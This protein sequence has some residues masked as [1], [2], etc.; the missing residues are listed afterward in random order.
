MEQKAISAGPV[1]FKVINVPQLVQSLFNTIWLCFFPLL[2]PLFFVFADGIQNQFTNRV[3]WYFSSIYLF[4]FFFV[5]GFV[6]RISC[7]AFESQDTLRENYSAVWDQ[8]PFKTNLHLKCITKS[9]A[10]NI[11]AVARCAAVCGRSRSLSWLAGFQICHAGGS[12]CGTHTIALS[13]YL[14]VAHYCNSCCCFAFAFASFS[15]ATRGVAV[16]ATV[17]AAAADSIT[18]RWSISCWHASNFSMPLSLSPS[19]SLSR[20]KKEIWVNA[21]ATIICFHCWLYLYL[22]CLRLFTMMLDAGWLL[23]V[24]L[25]L[26]LIRPWVGVICSAGRINSWKVN[27]MMICQLFGQ[28]PQVPHIDNY[29]LWVTI[30]MGK[31]S[32]F[33]FLWNI[34][35]HIYIQLY[36]YI[37]T[38]VYGII[39]FLHAMRLHM[40][41]CCMYLS[42]CGPSLSLQCKLW[43][44][45]HN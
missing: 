34:V 14:A 26:L 40:S 24:A 30:T 36:M 32:S 17:A 12:N 16:V 29:F 35:Q 7:A 18:W 4:V 22:L 38:Y 13:I 5:H 45:I 15:S 39:E 10:H 41:Q 8:L 33:H 21:Q 28:T 23:T 19:L 9:C 25:L 37:H 27:L 1:K 43:Q 3:P 42:V 44:A 11:L 6:C 2:F 31:R 20:A